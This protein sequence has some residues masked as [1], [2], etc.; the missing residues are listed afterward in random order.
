[1]SVYVVEG[2][3][4]DTT[5]PA[6]V[7]FVSAR[8]GR[9]PTAADVRV[10]GEMLL[11]TRGEPTDVTV[12]NRLRE[13]TAILWHGLELES[14][15]DGVPGWSG[16]GA[17]VAPSIAPGDS[18]T[19]RLSLRRAGTFIYHTH[20]NDVAQLSAGLYGALIVLEPGERWDPARDFVFIGAWNSAIREDAFVV[21]GGD[22]EPP[23]SLRVGTRYRL[24][25]IN[26]APAALVTFKIERDSALV[27]WQFIAKDGAD[28]PAHQ[29]RT[30]PA[31]KRISVGETFDVYVTPT[32]RGSYTLAAG[33]APRERRVYTRQIEV[34]R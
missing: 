3:A 5:H 12:H 6:N 31:T 14:W 21:N 7:S 9:E 19:A 11:L 30:G 13:N 10:P 34:R 1:V 33:Q 24:R 29:R 28:L 26:I 23:L 32:S 17:Q 15:S 20:L 25:F 27:E 2:V 8:N 4:K 22:S 16:Q 18:F